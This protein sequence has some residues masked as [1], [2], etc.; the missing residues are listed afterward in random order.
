MNQAINVVEVFSSIQGEGKYVGARQLFVRFAGCNLR[1][2]YC[3]TAESFAP[4]EKALIERN[5]GSREFLQIANPVQ[6][7]ALAE[8]MNRLL[9]ETPHQSISFTGGEPLLSAEIIKKLRPL[10]QGKFFLETN[11]TLPEKLSEVLPILDIISMD[12]KLP[13]LAGRAFWEEHRKF[14]QLA[15]SKE[16][17]VKLVVDKATPE[18][19]FK[20]AVDLLA[21]VDPH[22]LLIIQPVT[23]NTVCLSAPP[24]KILRLQELALQKLSDVRVIPQTHKFIGQL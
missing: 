22:I 2:R 18:E 20:R 8:H 14:L 23:P 5:A 16:L 9:A 4:P 12:I 21:A 6:V 11:G 15:S 17:F 10:V 13:Q 24:E 3:D 19:D 1:C 7:S